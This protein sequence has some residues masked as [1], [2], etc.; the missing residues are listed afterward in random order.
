MRELTGHTI[1]KVRMPQT[2]PRRRELTGETRIRLS[3]IKGLKEFIQDKHSGDPIGTTRTWKD[4]LEH[5]KTAHGW[6][7]NSNP[8]SSTNPMVKAEKQ[9]LQSWSSLYNQTQNMT[10]EQIFDKFPNIPKPIAMLPND[11][12]EHF[13]GVTNRSLYCG[14]AYFI[15]HM[16]HHHPE[17]NP[18]VYQDIQECINKAQKRFYDTKQNS[19]VLAI[20]PAPKLKELLVIKRDPE[21]NRLVLYK[22]RY[23]KK[24]NNYPGKF[25]QISPG[26]NNLGL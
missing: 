1:I 11:I 2:N 9:R 14:K 16:V 5:I 21:T 4:G 12:I 7:V 24:E 3:Q 15:D 13:P 18:A 8:G 23:Y 20:E 10:R 17:V 26:Q 6:I 19:L 22:S 25:K